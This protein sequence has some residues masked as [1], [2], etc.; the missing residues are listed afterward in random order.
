MIRVGLVGFG[1]AGRVFHAPTITAVEGLELAAVVERSSRNAEARYPGITTYASLEAMLADTSLSLIVI[2]TPNTSHVPLAHQ[3]LA[4]ERHVVVDKPM[5]I[6]SNEIPPLMQQAHAAGRLLIPYHNRRWDNGFRTLKQ[7]LAQQSVGRVVGFE[8]TFDRWRPA[9]RPGAWREKGLPG[10][11]ILLDLGTHLVD[12]ALQ[13]FG[14][15]LAI[16]ADVASERDHAEANDSFTVRLR[17][18][19]FIATLSG[20][21]LAAVSRP[22]YTLRGAHGEYIKWNLDPQEALLK[23]TGQIKEPGW[24]VEPEPDWGVLTTE[25]D[26]KLVNKPIEPIPGDYRLFYAGVRDAILNNAAPP[27]TA[28]DAWYAARVLEWAEQ[29]NAERREIACDWSDAPRNL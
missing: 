11:G 15:P 17:Y 16:S 1:M 23:A 4:A 13:L 7:L 5:A 20:N 8:S 24:G 25:V 29:S 6:S 3:V 22:H 19:G 18:Q 10:S 21:C 12:E 28:L 2:A 14:L 9:L 27:A 26:G